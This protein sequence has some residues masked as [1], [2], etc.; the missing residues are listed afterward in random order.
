MDAARRR[1][2]ASA[3]AVRQEVGG[4][5]PL[6]RR[7]DHVHRGDRRG[8]RGAGRRAGDYRADRRLLPD[9]GTAPAGPPAAGNR[10]AS[11]RQRGDDA[12]LANVTKAGRRPSESRGVAPFPFAARAAGAEFVAASPGVRS[13]V[14][15]GNPRGRLACPQ[16]LAHGFHRGPDMAEERLVTGTQVVQARLTVGRAGEPVHGTAAVAGETHV[17]P[18]AEPGK[19]IAFGR[20]ERYLT[21]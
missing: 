13:G 14:V 1:A 7:S 18:A 4:P 19:G 11:A 16:Q 8:F 2:A 15:I 20:A 12:D 3:A 5:A 9:A 17:A 6:L 10:A 21:W